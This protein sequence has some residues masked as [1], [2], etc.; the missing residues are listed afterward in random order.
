[1][2]LNDILKK[3][4]DILADGHVLSNEMIRDADI[5]VIGHFGNAVSLNIWTG[6]CALTHDRM[7]TGNLG[8]MIKAIVELLCLEDENGFCFS[9]LKDIPVRIISDGPF[10]K[11]LGFGHFMKNRFVYTDDLNKL[12]E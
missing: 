11:V 10:T 4:E 7:N 5:L 9:K 1:M 2:K 6:C 3:E 8:I 12:T